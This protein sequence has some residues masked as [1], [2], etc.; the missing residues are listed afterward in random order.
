MPLLQD[1]VHAPA[2]GAAAA[3]DGSNSD[4]EVAAPNN[5]EEVTVG[6]ADVDLHRCL[7]QARAEVTAAGVGSHAAVADAA[8]TDKVVTDAASSAM[9]RQ[10]CYACNRCKHDSLA[11]LLV[12]HL[13]ARFRDVGEE[14]GPGSR[15]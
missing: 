8:V 7:K 6:V 14:C 9:W 2:P 3:D 4:A 11:R 5:I 15:A 10:A 1:V 13:C 12:T